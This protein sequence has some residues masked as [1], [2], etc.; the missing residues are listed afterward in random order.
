[1]EMTIKITYK[2]TNVVYQYVGHISTSDT[3]PWHSYPL[4]FQRVF[5]P[6]IMS[7]ITQEAR[8]TLAIKA[9]RTSRKLSRRKAAK[10]YQVPYSTLCDRMNGR[11]TLR[12]SHLANHHSGRP[13]CAPW[14]VPLAPMPPATCPAIMVDGR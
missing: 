5:T 10:L 11:T 12:V 14:P 13:G 8:I 6:S 2:V 1:M 4:T 9:I 3:F 7:V